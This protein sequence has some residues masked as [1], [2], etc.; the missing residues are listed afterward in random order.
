MLN[1]QYRLTH[2]VKGSKN[3]DELKWAKKVA[4]KIY[5]KYAESSELGYVGLNAIWADMNHGNS[6]ALLEN[7]EFNPEYERISN[8]FTKAGQR[9]IAKNHGGVKNGRIIQLNGNDALLL[10]D[11][12]GIASLHYTI[13]DLD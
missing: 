8:I 1:R 6:S 10:N 3:N 13:E 12:T 2:V 4:L 9:F 11:K 5:N 7:G